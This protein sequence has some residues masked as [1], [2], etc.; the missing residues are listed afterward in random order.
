VSND[1]LS[2]IERIEILQLLHSPILGCLR[3]KG[4]NPTCG[5]EKY[6]LNMESPLRINLYVSDL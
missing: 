3:L 5:Q 2:L 1:L 6:W 4:I